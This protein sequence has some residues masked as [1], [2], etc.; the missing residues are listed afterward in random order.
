M[1]TDGLQEVNGNQMIDTKGGD[2]RQS[3]KSVSSSF[4]QNI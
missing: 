4:S 1:T 3:M 2:P